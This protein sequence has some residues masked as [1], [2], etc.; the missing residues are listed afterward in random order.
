M[1]MMFFLGG[2][3]GAATMAVLQINSGGERNP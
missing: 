2:L 3:I 1:K